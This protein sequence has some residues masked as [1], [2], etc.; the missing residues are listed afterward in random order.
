MPYIADE[1]GNA[2]YVTA[3]DPRLATSSIQGQAGSFDATATSDSGPASVT[4]TSSSGTGA[5]TEGQVEA[6]FNQVGAQIETPYESASA[7]LAR[8]TQ[9][10]NSGARTE[11]E[12]KSAIYATAQPG[13]TFDENA[14]AMYGGP[15]ASQLSS[16][17]GGNAEV[18]YDSTA[19][20]WYLAY[21]VPGT[22]V[23]LLYSATS[24]Q[25]NALFPDG[26]I[27]ADRTV[28]T[29]LIQQMGGIFA[30]TA[31]DPYG[32]P[33]GSFIE[34]LEREAAIR[35]WL[36]DPDILAIMFE[37]ALEGRSVSDAELMQTEWWRT[38]NEAQRA[39]MT[40]M[41]S[42]PMTAMQTLEQAKVSTRNLLIQAGMANP[43]QSVIDK[44]AG[45]RVTGNWT[46]GYYRNQI[47]AIS[48]PSSGI[49]ID[50][51]LQSV[52]GGQNLDTTQQFENT[53]RTLAAEWLGP[54]YG[55][56]DDNQ[57]RQWAG[58][59]RNDPD[60]ETQLVEMLRGQR[61][62]LFPEYTNE[63]LRYV[64]I[65]GPWKNMIQN[66]WGQTADETDQVFQ[67]LLRMNDYSEAGKLLR[68]EGLKRGIGT[69]TQSIQ[70]AAAETGGQVRRI[71]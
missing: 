6:W 13:W 63:Q 55:S 5:Y 33:Y 66:V 8:I 16:T 65:A 69:V 62:A 9:Q 32:N 59:F 4:S 18:W 3:D 67:Q 50:A 68:R 28:T 23:P 21:Q 22:D 34:Q 58:R 70:S 37:A 36:N 26:N 25:L 31:E 39:W 47:L 17:T 64:D 60:A 49:S 48:D 41:E 2:I 40:L 1:N 15:G 54:V 45:E 43:P 46:D 35:P 44:L 29:Q 57:I 30:G 20:A 71:F 56:W 52:I 38:H 12:V 51:G 10:L 27:K 24:Q 14:V 42:D 7:R 53:V 11:D 61:M 19:G